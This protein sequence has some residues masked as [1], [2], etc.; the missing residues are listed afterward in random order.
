M[1]TNY[2]LLQKSF[3]GL[4]NQNFDHSTKEVIDNEIIL[5]AMYQRF[6]LLNINVRYCIIFL[7]CE[8]VQIEMFGNRQAVL[9]RVVLLRSLVAKDCLQNTLNH[10]RLT[11]FQW[12]PGLHSSL[13]S[14]TLRPFQG[15]R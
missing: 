4:V 9:I 7:H 3:S 15:N 13:H 6:A 5:V 11:F 12:S 14:I 2:L 8:F 1:G 10:C